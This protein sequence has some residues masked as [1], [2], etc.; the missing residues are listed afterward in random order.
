MSVEAKIHLSKF[1]MELVNNTDWILTKQ[2]ILKKVYLLFGELL[3]K[4]KSISVKEQNLLP[5]FDIEKNGKIF[6]GDNYLGLPYVMLD[7]PAL[8]KKEDIFAV[9]TMFLWG[10]FFSITLHISGEH[11]LKNIVVPDILNHLSE[12]DFFICIAEDEWQHL[13]D[14]TNYVSV[15]DLDEQQQAAISLKN[16]F[17][18]SKKIELSKWNETPGFLEKT[19]GE[20]IDI[21]KLSYRSHYLGIKLPDK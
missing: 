4:Y 9:R 19:Y 2:S 13:F 18:I 17:K 12:S 20:I 16:F 14:N 10:N 21:I 5:G 6:K 7:Y 3:E 1:E 8:F 11:K 15:K